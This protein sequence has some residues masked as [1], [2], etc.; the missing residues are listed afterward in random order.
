MTLWDEYGGTSTAH[1]HI[2]LE[3]NQSRRAVSSVARPSSNSQDF[4]AQPGPDRDNNTVDITRNREQPIDLRHAH[5]G[6]EPPQ[7]ALEGSA[8]ASAES[9]PRKTTST[10][11]K[12]A[13]AAP[14]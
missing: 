11:A 7:C 12:A 4:V 5:A 14:S 10:S 8:S 9:A 13:P 2:F 3:I 6:S 1:Q